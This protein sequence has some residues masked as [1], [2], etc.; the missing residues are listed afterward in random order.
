MT[1][2]FGI[3]EEAREIGEIRE[4]DK[5]VRWLPVRS[6]RI[7]EPIKVYGGNSADAV[8]MHLAKVPLG[9]DEKNL[10]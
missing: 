3:V 2:T 7:Y 8:K 10:Q 5:D 1:G 9:Q 4:T 6:S